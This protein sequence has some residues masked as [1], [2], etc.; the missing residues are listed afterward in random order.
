MFI[1]CKICISFEY[2]LLEFLNKISIKFW[3]N[4]KKYFEFFWKNYENY[5]M[6]LRI[7]FVLWNY[8]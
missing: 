8:E 4:L 3:L 7:K 6:G 1:F 2:N 5:F